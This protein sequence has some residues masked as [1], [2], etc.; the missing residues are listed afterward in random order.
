MHQQGRSNG[1]SDFD[2]VAGVQSPGNPNLQY[3]SA[4]PAVGFIPAPPNTDSVVAAAAVSCETSCSNPIAVTTD[5]AEVTVGFEGACV[6]S[7]ELPLSFNSS[8]TATTSSDHG[9]EAKY[10]VVWI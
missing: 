9:I 3:S 10:R 1:V 8:A 5:K 7:M 4:S 2:P 6:S